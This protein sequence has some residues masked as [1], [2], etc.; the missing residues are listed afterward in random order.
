MVIAFPQDVF[1]KSII[2][3]GQGRIFF[4]ACRFQVLLTIAQGAWLSGRCLLRCNLAAGT[5][6]SLEDRVW[7][8]REIF[9]LDV[10]KHFR[11]QLRHSIL[12]R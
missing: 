2:Q 12:T 9:D 8:W 11:K 7:G 4:S 1:C 3:V 6:T 10:L 5:Q